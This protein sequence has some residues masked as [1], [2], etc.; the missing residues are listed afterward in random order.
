MSFL[1]FDSRAGC[2]L[3]PNVTHDIHVGWICDM[4]M[5]T[6]AHRKAHRQKDPGIR[7]T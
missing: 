7:E 4:M 1:K 2:S 6:N 3:Y 5:W